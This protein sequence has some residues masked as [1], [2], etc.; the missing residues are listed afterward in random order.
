MRL[1][2]SALI[3]GDLRGHG[4]RSSRDSLLAGTCA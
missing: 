2:A 3:R 1:I 4:L